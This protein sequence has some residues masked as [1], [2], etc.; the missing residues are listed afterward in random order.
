[1]IGFNKRTITVTALT[2]AAAVSIFGETTHGAC[3]LNQRNVSAMQI[4]EWKDT[5]ILIVD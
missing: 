3:L 1:M 2:G 5:R 4:E